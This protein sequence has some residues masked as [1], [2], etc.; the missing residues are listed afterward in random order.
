MVNKMLWLPESAASLLTTEL[1][2][3]AAAA[4]IVDGADYVNATNK[5]RWADFF[6]Q[7]TAFDDVPHTGDNVELHLFYKFDGTLYAD[8]EAGDVNTP[9]PSANSFHGLFLIEAAVG[10][11]HQQL[12]QVPLS[13]FDFRAAVVLNISHDLTAVD[14]HYLKMY[15]YSEEMQ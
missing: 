8:G 6:L 15:P 13:P 11:Q 2:N 9:T 7:L 10:P 5:F 3:A 12:L 1:N 4:I 14:T